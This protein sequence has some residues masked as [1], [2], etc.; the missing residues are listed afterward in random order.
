MAFMLSFVREKL[1]S[2]PWIG[3]MQMSP[4]STHLSLCLPA[5]LMELSTTGSAKIPAW[6]PSLAPYRG[7]FCLWQQNK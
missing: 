3:V 4:L 7:R 2:Q 1:F 6:R 5:C